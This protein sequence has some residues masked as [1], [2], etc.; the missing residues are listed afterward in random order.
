METTISNF[1]TSFYIPGIKKLAFHV[2][3]V[4]MLGTSHFGDS[5]QT[6]FKPCKYFQ[7]V[8]CH[9]DYAKRVVAIFPIK[10]NQNNTVGIY[11]C[12]LRMFHWK[13]SVRYLSQE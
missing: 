6:A 7:D 2:P 8:L 5:H 9:C 1:H 11:L 12:L 4:Q 3:H 10:Y 13:I